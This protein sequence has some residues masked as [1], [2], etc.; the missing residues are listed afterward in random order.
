[1][2]SMAVQDLTSIVTCAREHLLDE[3]EAN[4]QPEYVNVIVIKQKN[5]GVA[6]LA[7]PCLPG[8]CQCVARLLYGSQTVT[9]GMG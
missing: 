4:R 7:R 2:E 3:L 6:I 9:V 1:M 8:S 5:S